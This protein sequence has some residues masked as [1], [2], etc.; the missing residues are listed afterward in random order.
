MKLYKE[1]DDIKKFNVTI[2]KWNKYKAQK[3][4]CK[5]LVKDHMT[6]VSIMFDRKKYIR[7][8]TSLK[9]TFNDKLANFGKYNQ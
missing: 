1:I 4:L 7:T 9:A 2:Q 8:I 3:E 5:I 6:K